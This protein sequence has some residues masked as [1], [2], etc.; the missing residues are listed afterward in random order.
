MDFCSLVMVNTEKDQEIKRQRLC[1]LGHIT[2]C[3]QQYGSF[4]SYR[5]SK[6]CR[7]KKEEL[8][9]SSHRSSGEGAGSLWCFN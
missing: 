3:G 1:W 9:S 6:W 5:R 8:S 2:Q 7:S 4:K